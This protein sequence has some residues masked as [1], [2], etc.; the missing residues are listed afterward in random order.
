MAN[1]PIANIVFHEGITQASD[2]ETY[3]LSP[4]GHT[5]NIDFM[6]TGT[7]T[8]IVEGKI[9]NESDFD[10]IMVVDLATYNMTTQPNTFHTYQC[11]VT[12]WSYL[13]VRLVSVNGSITVIGKLVG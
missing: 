4:D 2:G 13:R 11:D 5:M 9:H 8:A 7:F 1:R 3:A 12:A 10:E 6:G